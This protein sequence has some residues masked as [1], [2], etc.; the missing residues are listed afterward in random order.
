MLFCT[1]DDKF[2]P[3]IGAVT[4]GVLVGLTVIEVST[5]FVI[6]VDPTLHIK[7]F[8]NDLH[9]RSLGPQNSPDYC[10]ALG[11]TVHCLTYKHP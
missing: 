11:Q 1:I 2:V 5:A 6:S 10:N 4:G 3:Y 9:F 7:L 8:E